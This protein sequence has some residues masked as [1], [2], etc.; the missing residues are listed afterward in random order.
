MDTAH[1]GNDIALIKGLSKSTFYLKIFWLDFRQ[2][3]RI[4]GGASERLGGGGGLRNHKE[5]K[6][7]R[8]G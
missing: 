3:C 5:D 1:R 4:G 6:E 7:G 8:E 2:F